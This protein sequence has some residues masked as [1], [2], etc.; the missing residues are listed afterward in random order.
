LP[1]K[2]K[3]E[4]VQPFL[5]IDLVAAFFVQKKTKSG[6]DGFDLQQPLLN[7]ARIFLPVLRPLS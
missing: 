7:S 5:L 2:K 3:H 4:D 6:S 1:S